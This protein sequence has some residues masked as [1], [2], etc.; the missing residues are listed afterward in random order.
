MKSVLGIDLGTQSLK[1]LFY[2]F[3]EHK[4]LVTASSSLDLITKS[5][6]T[7]EQLVSW[8]TQALATCME[9]ISPVI[10]QSV[11]AI[12][13]SGQQHG[14]IALDEQGEALIPVKLWCCLLYTSDAADE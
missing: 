7:A 5:D 13:V 11:M 12:S 10:K 3:E 1:V 6:G 4:V 9:Q 2:D 8:W 14:F